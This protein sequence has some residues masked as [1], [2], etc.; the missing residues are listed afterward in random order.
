[1]SHGIRALVELDPPIGGVPMAIK[2]TRNK[3]VQKTMVEKP[4]EDL[5]VAS[6]AIREEE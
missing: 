1:M 2:K 6:E 3:L 5:N 4:I